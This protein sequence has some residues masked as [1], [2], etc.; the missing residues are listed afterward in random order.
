MCGSPRN[1]AATI[2]AQIAACRL[3]GARAGKCSDV[4]APTSAAGFAEIVDRTAKRMRAPSR[5]CRT[6]IYGFEDVMDD[7][8]LGTSTSRSR[9]EE[10]PIKGDRPSSISPAPAARC[11]ATSTSR[12][13]ATQA[14][15]CYSLKALLDPDVPNNQGVLDLPDMVTPRARW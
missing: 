15:V 14:A 9:L 7:D 4:T 12:I 5:A 3:G 11:A 1:G 13:N 8:G 6:A 2:I 10:S